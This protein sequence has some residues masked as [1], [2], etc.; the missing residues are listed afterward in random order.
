MN[1]SIDLYSEDEVQGEFR[2]SIEQ[3]YSELV[4]WS[5]TVPEKVQADGY[6]PNQLL[7]ATG[8]DNSLNLRI[9]CY[10]ELEQDSLFLAVVATADA[11][12]DVDI[13][14]FVAE[15]PENGVADVEYG[16]NRKPS[17]RYLQTETIS[18]DGRRNLDVVDEVIDRMS[19]LTDK[20]KNKSLE[21]M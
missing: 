16:N 2:D 13:E 7:V 14:V 18:S 4:D 10:L 17:R 15:S 3:F 21:D 8:Y 1:P 9:P 11:Y 19:T 6:Q 5:R 12:G 20:Y